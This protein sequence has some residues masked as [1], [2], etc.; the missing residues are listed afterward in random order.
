MD[1]RKCQ[2]AT[3]SPA[4]P[5]GLPWQA[6]WTRGRRRAGRSQPPARPVL[7]WI[8]QHS[9][10]LCVISESRNVGGRLAKVVPRLRIR[11]KTEKLLGSSCV[12]DESS[13]MQ[14]CVADIPRCIHVSTAGG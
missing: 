13:T 1:C 12:A 14:R 4:E 5:G 2:T 10:Q 7:P 6:S 3:A 11:S 8:S 9:D